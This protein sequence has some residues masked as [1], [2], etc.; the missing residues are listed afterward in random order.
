MPDH[1]LLAIQPLDPQEDDTLM[2]VLP[3]S[4]PSAEENLASEELRE[5]FRHKLAAFAATLDDRYADILRNR[6]LSDTPLTLDDIGQKYHIS[7]ERARQ[8]E[9]KIIK[10]LREFMKKEVKDFELLRPT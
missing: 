10:R 5:L 2:D 7:R 8:L 3:S 4:G 1:R 9:E 6:I